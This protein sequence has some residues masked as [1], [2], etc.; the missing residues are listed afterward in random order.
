MS[1]FAY[2]LT[3]PCDQCDDRRTV[4]AE[5]PYDVCRQSRFGDCEPLD[6]MTGEGCVKLAAV[7]ELSDLAVAV[8][9]TRFR[10]TPPEV[11]DQQIRGFADLFH[12]WARD[13]DAEFDD[14]GWMRDCSV[15]RRVRAAA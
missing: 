3:T 13:I 4:R 11:R 1:A 5:P 8:A 7:E 15:A 2:I 10:H 12:D 6:E 9:G 14:E